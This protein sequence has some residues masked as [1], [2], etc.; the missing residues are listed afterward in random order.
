MGW[1]KVVDDNSLAAG[2]TRRGVERG[3]ENDEPPR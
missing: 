1:G 3:R 2:V